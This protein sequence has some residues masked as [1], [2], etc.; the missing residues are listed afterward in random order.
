MTRPHRSEGGILCGT[1]PH[2]FFFLHLRV[3]RVCAGGKVEK[4]SSIY[5]YAKLHYLHNMCETHWKRYPQTL[6]LNNMESKQTGAGSQLH[7]E[8]TGSSVKFTSLQGVSPSH[9]ETFLCVFFFFKPLGM[10]STYWLGCLFNTSLSM[11]CVTQTITKGHLL[12][13]IVKD[14][15]G[16][17]C[18]DYGLC[19]HKPGV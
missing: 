12:K 3:S 11:E 5:F 17:F 18:Q 1:K 8:S 9:I 7:T 14:G 13:L 10:T 16:R 19:V 15:R 6:H 2:F 4:K